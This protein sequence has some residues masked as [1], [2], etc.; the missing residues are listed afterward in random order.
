MDIIPTGETENDGALFFLAKMNDAINGTKL[1][2]QNIRKDMA[3][4]TFIIMASVESAE[5]VL[6]AVMS[7][8]IQST[9]LFYQ[10][11]L[12]VIC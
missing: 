8:I 6:D 2:L 3:V 5:K 4:R 1:Q 11:D 10:H 7:F 9:I 12:P